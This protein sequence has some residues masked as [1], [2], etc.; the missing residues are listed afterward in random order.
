MEFKI[1]DRI[2]CKKGFQTRSSGESNYGGAGYEENMEFTI[3][4][5]TEGSKKLGMQIIWSDKVNGGVYSNA[6]ELIKEDSKF[7][8]NTMNKKVIKV[9]VFNKKSGKI[10]KE[11]TVTAV[12][13]SQAVLKAYGVDLDNTQ[14][15]TTVLDE[16]DEPAKPMVVKVE[17]P[18]G[19]QK[20]Q[21]E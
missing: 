5:I 1:G 12:D 2:R 21:K 6:L 16:Y 11:E 13:E 4:R 18:K 20:K 8:A 10:E 9:L 19:T 17:T 15:K 3:D 14:I 7:P